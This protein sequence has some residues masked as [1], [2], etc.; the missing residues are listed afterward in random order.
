VSGGF[1]EHVEGGAEFCMGVDDRRPV[2][3]V[4]AALFGAF[5]DDRESPASDR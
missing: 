5:G 4:V 1:D 2:T 3:R